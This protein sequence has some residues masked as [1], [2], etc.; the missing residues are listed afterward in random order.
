VKGVLIT[1]AGGF[2]G[3][4]AVKEFLR[5][6]WRVFGLVHRNVPS[7][8]E[9]TMA[10]RAPLTLVKGDVTDRGQ[11][12]AVME[13]VTREHGAPL[14]AIV[15]AAG[16]ASDVGRRSAFRKA[17]FESVQH[18]VELTTEFDVC[19]F[20]FVSTTDVYGLLDH[21]GERE[22]DLPYFASLNNPYPYYKIAAEKWIRKSLPPDRYSIIRPAQVWGAGDTTLTPRFISFLKKSPW[23][24]HFG[25]RRGTNRWP[26]AHVKNVAAALYLGATAAEAAGQA[27][28]VSDKELT[29]IDE[30][31][32]IVGAAA[33]PEK[34]FRSVTLPF[35][36]GWLFGTVTSGISNLLNSLHP[37]ADPSLY[38]LYAVSRNLD[39]SNGRFREFMAAA[40]R[41]I[42]T[43]EE[44]LRELESAL[45][46]AGR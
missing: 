40:G 17:N 22:E 41:K 42:V 3:G 1:G 26:L 13:R 34:R 36:M 15:H 24:I 33:F 8:L 30:F 7:S 12:H 6:G 45:A 35:W 16:R 32:R 38:A 29:T 11:L 46:E 2:I 19:R 39:F 10:G 18:L 28:T 21:N 43:R 14:D 23:I 31:Y 9:E 20:V 37:I 25:R 5:E 4:Y 27:F 44:G